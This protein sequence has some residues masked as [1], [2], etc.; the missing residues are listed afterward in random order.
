MD[1]LRVKMEEFTYEFARKMFLEHPIKRVEITDR[2]PRVSHLTDV[3]GSENGRDISETTAWYKWDAAV[4]PDGSKVPG[5]AGWQISGTVWC[6]DLEPLFPS[7]KMAKE[8]LSDACVDSGRR[9]A[10]LP[11][12]NPL[13]VRPG[14]T[15]PHLAKSGTVYQIFGHKGKYVVMSSLAITGPDGAPP[16]AYFLTTRRWDTTY[17]IGR[18]D[19]PNAWMTEILSMAFHFRTHREAK[20]AM[21]SAIKSDNYGFA[22]RQLLERAKAVAVPE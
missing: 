14:K 19:H 20:A 21:L 9:L 8:I 10:S 5:H 12:M 4:R 16:R 1:T 15:W 3:I 7:A 2:E 11:E 13:I 17:D 6:R 22:E 18:G